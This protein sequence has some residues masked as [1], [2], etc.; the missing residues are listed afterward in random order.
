MSDL[1]TNMK[2]YTLI[3]PEGLKVPLV[4]SSP[5][6]GTFFPKEVKDQ[7]NQKLIEAPDDTDW[8]IHQLYDFA[9]EMGMTL[10]A[11]TVSRWVIDLNRNP[12]SAPL[13]N[14]GR[15]LTG[16]CPAQNFRGDDL[17]LDKAPDE[18]EV[19]RRLKNYY[20]PYYKRIQ[21]LL[22]ELKA[23]FGYAL[24]WE[25]HS[26]R[27]H[28]PLIQQEPFPDLIL[29]DNDGQSCNTNFSRVVLD[30]LVK[31]GHKITY[32]TPFKGGHLTRYFGQPDKHQHAF[33]LEMTKLNYMDDTQKTYSPRRANRI[34]ESLNLVFKELLSAAAKYYE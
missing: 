6:S 12:E 24:L 11:A 23:Q 10:I 31:R 33:Q 21:A 20:W 28:V 15:I 2:P 26:I 8:F 3:E 19:N 34:R 1:R 30:Q 29:G 22:D 32:N 17:Y 7:F 4:I 14:D 9:S 5:H 25:A 13:Y 16:L 27:N 18:S